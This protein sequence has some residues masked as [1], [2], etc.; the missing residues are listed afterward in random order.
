M[1]D[2]DLFQFVT[3]NAE[4]A[5]P[6]RFTMAA[7]RE[8]FDRESVVYEAGVRD[9]MER[10]RAFKTWVDEHIPPEH[11]KDEAVTTCLAFIQVGVPMYPQDA[12]RYN[13]RLLELANMQVK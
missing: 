11:H 8:L 12:D 1:P 9:R 3:P 10:L 5:P 13:A 6:F 2:P 7:L 4:T